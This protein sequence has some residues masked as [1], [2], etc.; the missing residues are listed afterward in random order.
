MTRKDNNGNWGPRGRREVFFP[1]FTDN[2]NAHVASPNSPLSR[3]MSQATLGE[4]KLPEIVDKLKDPNCSVDEIVR[5]IAVQMTLVAQE[6]RTSGGDG[7][8]AFK[9]KNLMGQLRALCAL[10]KTVKENFALVHREVVDLE[11]PVFQFVLG[12]IVRLFLETI[13]SVF[14]GDTSTAKSVWKNFILSVEKYQPDL[15]HK[16]KMHSRGMD[17]L[18]SY[19]P[20]KEISEL[21]QAIK[22]KNL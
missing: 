7:A 6:M 5:L 16:L 11:G 2:E 20:S 4:S 1:P 12:E 19:L 14:S 18:S 8:T 21:L 22:G 3:A 13:I 15:R 10:D 17:V 9:K